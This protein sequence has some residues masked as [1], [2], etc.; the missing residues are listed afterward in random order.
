MGAEL[1]GLK[2]SEDSVEAT[3]LHHQR[4]S[5]APMNVG[6]PPQREI[7]SYKWVVGADGA[8]GT[9]RRQLGLTFVGETRSENF[10]IGDIILDEG[11]GLDR[12]VRHEYISTGSWGACTHLVSTEVAHLGRY[13]R[14]FVSTL[15]FHQI[16][17]Q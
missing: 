1:Q 6:I 10:V 17:L 3:I 12:N 14:R 2:L 16:L 5:E 7:V 9:V 11:T 4:D 13:L 15:H 8:R